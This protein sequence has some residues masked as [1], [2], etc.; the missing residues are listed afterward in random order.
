M[1]RMLQVVKFLNLNYMKKLIRE[2]KMKDVGLSILV[3]IVV[4][5]TIGGLASRCWWKDDNAIE[6]IAEEIIEKE[7][8]VAIDLSPATPENP[9]D[10]KFK[11]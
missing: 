10:L 11:H 5:C 1:R 7:T 3:A 8:G 9:P 6:E 2:L 4:I